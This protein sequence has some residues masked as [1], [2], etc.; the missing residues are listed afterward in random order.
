MKMF[1]IGNADVSL[2]RFSQVYLLSAAFILAITGS[3]KVPT[4][5]I[6]KMCIE[7][8]V[9]GVYQPLSVSNMGLSGFIAST[10]LAIV[11]LIC[12]SP[13]RWLPCLAAGSWGAL[14]LAIRLTLFKNG[15]HHCNCL[16][17]VDAPPLTVEAIA[18]WLAIGGGIAFWQS[19][20]NSAQV[21][22]EPVG[23]KMTMGIFQRLLWWGVA[24][25]CCVGGAAHPP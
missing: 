8:P 1:R 4:D 21:A 11:A 15:F 9:L 16:G 24:G 2:Q 5:F 19:W 22:H 12:L 20:H 14:C 6:L 25:A 23:Q 17:W 13:V 3:G 10:E 18:A 7:E